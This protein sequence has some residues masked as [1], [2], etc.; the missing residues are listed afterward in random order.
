L[1]ASICVWSDLLYI[2]Q[3]LN[4]LAS[5]QLFLRGFIQCGII[6]KGDTEKRFVGGS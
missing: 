4:I 6:C 3:P 1:L 5:G 2:S